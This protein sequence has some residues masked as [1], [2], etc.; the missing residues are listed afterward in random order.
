MDER[1]A[2]SAEIPSLRRYARAL[3]SDPVAAEDLVQ[4]CLERALSRLHL[5]RPDTSMRTWLFTIM[6]NIHANAA[7][8]RSKRPDTAP[9]DGATENRAGVRHGQ[10][11]AVALRDL[12]RALRELPSEQR[13]VV[14]LVG[15]E[16]MSYRQVAEVLDVPIGT[17]MSRLS[18]GR[19]RLRRSM[20]G[21][22]T[23]VLRRIK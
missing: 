1:D 6:H 15:L 21:D 22:D 19:E 16:D 13:A 23:P 11:D 8:R 3:L 18:R 20:E 17:V 5:F 4:D 9:L 12:S 14:L 2:I 7:R 10:E